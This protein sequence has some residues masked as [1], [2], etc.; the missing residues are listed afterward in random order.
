MVHNP[1]GVRPLW[2]ANLYY[3]FGI[4]GT[5]L[6]GYGSFEY[7]SFGDDPF[8]VRPLRGTTLLGYDTFGV[9]SFWGTP[10]M[11]YKHCVVRPFWDTSF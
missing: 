3:P 6:L 8:V 5:T 11:G 1:F 9:R 10:Y 2:G 7:D 4:R